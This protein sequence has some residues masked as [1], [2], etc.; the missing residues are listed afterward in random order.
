MTD[1]VARRRS[2]SL[3]ER[4]GRVKGF[5]LVRQMA[6]ALHTSCLSR[7]GST[8]PNGDGSC[9]DS[10]RTIRPTG[11]AATFAGN[12]V[13]ILAGDIQCRPSILT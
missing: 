5:E 11:V 2:S 7:C 4:S 12:D 6:K 3:N 9:A 13:S 1:F 8:E 10:P